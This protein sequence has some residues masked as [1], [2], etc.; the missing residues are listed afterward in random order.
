M[1]ARF[2]KY[3]LL[4]WLFAKAGNS[5]AQITYTIQVILRSN[6]QED[7]LYDGTII[8]IFGFTNMLSQPAQLPAKTIYCMVGDSVVL[9]AKSI[10]QYDHHTIHLHG[11]D[12][13]TRN[14]GDPSTSFDLQHM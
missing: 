14:D 4:L 10:S 13:D 2:I 6:A 7:T 12:V 3:V 5:V 9:D 1:N 11:L 8:P